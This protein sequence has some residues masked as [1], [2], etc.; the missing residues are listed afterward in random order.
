MVNCDVL[1]RLVH[2]RQALWDMKHKNYH[3]REISRKLWIEI[4][5][6]M[7]TTR[8]V[9]KKKW[10]NLRTT[11]RRIYVKTL[12]TL[13]PVSKW[14]YFHSLS[15]LSDNLLPRR[16]LHTQKKIDQEFSFSYDEISNSEYFSNTEFIDLSQVGFEILVNPKKEINRKQNDSLIDLSSDLIEV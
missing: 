4:A 3:N 1:I 5:V 2:D 9:V 8:H 10:H 12:S 11:Y 14:K 15:F 13:G 6:E 7:K 16:F